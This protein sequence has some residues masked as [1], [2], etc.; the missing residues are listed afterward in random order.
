[1]NFLCFGV[2]AIGTY[3]GGSLAASGQRVVFID[4][5]AVVDQVRSNGLHLHYHG[6]E[7]QVN[8]P[9]VVGSLEEALNLSSYDTAILAVKSFDTAAVLAEAQRFREQM[10]PVLCLQNGVENEARIAETLGPEKAVSGTVTTAIGRGKVGHI[11]VEK[12]RGV[13]VALDH[14]MGRSLVN[15][16]NAAGLKA[17]GYANGPSLKWSKMLTN[18]LANASSA[19][20]DMSPTEIFS[21]PGLY[22]I[23]S[24]MFKEALATMNAQS[25]LVC[26]LPATPV[27][28]LTLIIRTLPPAI[29][30]PLLVRTLGKGRGGKMPS[31]HI[32]LYGGRGKSEVDYLNGAVVRFGKRLRVAT[33]VNR[34]LNQTLLAL[35]NG[36]L[37]KAEYAHQPKK[38][39]QDITSGRPLHEHTIL[40]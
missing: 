27:R 18:L 29:S 28:L 32:D 3:I 8:H 30:R 5:P 7:K 38:Y 2:G 1:M 17:R 40:G 19:I 9:E 10:P 21:H 24:W 15:A 23:E 16:M 11:T 33:P 34:W 31:F 37:A 36:T 39:I 14:P 20:L 26:D 13:G 4:R 12:L 22:R 6:Q 35:T 25:I